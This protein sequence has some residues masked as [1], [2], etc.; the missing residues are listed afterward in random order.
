M[1]SVVVAV[2]SKV[3]SE[4]STPRFTRKYHGLSGDYVLYVCEKFSFQ[5]CSQWSAACGE[6]WEAVPTTFE[7]LCGTMGVNGRKS[8]TAVPCT[9]QNSQVYHA[10]RAPAYSSALFPR[11]ILDPSGQQPGYVD[12]LGLITQL[13]F[14]LRRLA[15]HSRFSGRMVPHFSGTAGRRVLSDYTAPEAARVMPLFSN[16][17]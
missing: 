7:E 3:Q 6:V 15:S 9:A 10:A 11:R 4:S 8:H 17:V 13:V 1:Y 14:F 12:V 2:Q 5:P 16:R